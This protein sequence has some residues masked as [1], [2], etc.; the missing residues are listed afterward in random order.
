MVSFALYFIKKA[1]TVLVTAKQILA[2]NGNCL[3][4][5]RKFFYVLGLEKKS[6]S[7][8]RKLSP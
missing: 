2:H 6:W 4:W 3:S 5:P 7:W 1:Y 8:P